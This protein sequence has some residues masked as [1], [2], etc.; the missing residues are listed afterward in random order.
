MNMKLIDKA[1]MILLLLADVLAI[2]VGMFA[3]PS[4]HQTVALAA[5]Y[6]SV[7]VSACIIVYFLILWKK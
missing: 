5:S 6:C 1:V 4:G 3:G 7:I 2:I